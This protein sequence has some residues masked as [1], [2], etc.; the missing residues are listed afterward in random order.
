MKTGKLSES[1]LKRSV[2]KRI[3]TGAQGILLPPSAG[4]D[5]SAFEAGD[6]VIVSAS[7]A[8]PDVFSDYIRYPV[9]SAVNNI[10]ASG[11]MPIG[12]MVTG[13]LPE[14]IEETE[15]KALS[16]EIDSLCKE[17]GISALGGHTQ[18]TPAVDRPVISV[19]ALGKTKKEKLITSSGAGPGDEIVVTKWIGLAG[20]GI[21]AHERE[22]IIGRKLKQGLINE[23][24]MFSG[25]ISVLPEARIAADYG[26]H[27]MHDLSQGGIY[28]GLW[29][30]AGS[31]RKGL[32][33]DLKKIPIRQETVEICEIFDINPYRLLSGGSMLI[34]VADG[35]GLAGLLEENDIPAVVIGRFTDSND[36]IIINGD[37]VTYLD[38]PKQE[39]LIRIKT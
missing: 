34:A 37:E 16:D 3:R 10:A 6:E 27:A 15:L 36:R 28:N 9:M 19:T 30:M 13:F 7:G 8:F 26:V 1:V 24:K 2:F 11:A 12:I 18:V 25:M 17:L 20:T 22:E 35:E 14:A 4:T 33:A 21:L 32:S 38:S 23:A 31:S 39:E 29:E 5:I